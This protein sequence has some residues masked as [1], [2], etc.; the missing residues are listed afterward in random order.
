MAQIDTGGGPTRD[1]QLTIIP[2]IDLM[3]CLTAFLL[4][5]AV[6]TNTAQLQVEPAGRAAEGELCK[7]GDVCDEPKL[8]VLIEGD[9]VSIA[10]SRLNEVVRIPKTAQGYDWDEVERRLA[11]HKA[12]AYFA[13]TTEIEI[14][15]QSREGAPVEYQALVAA[16][17]TAIK[18]GF[19]HVGYTDPHGLSAASAL[20]Y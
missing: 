4:F 7:P 12:S 18:A 20:V 14:A 11:R 2:F 10:V 16:S 9:Q 3:S 17:D 1:V 19:A 6:W 15:A 13:D 8:S 5:A